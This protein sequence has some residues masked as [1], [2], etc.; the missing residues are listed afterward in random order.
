MGYRYGGTHTQP[1]YE[2]AGGSGL[3]T[4]RVFEVAFGGHPY[5]IDWS[6]EAPLHH[7]TVPMTREQADV[8][9]SPGEQ[10]INREA[11]WR[12]F[13][14]SWHHG[15]GQRFFDRPESLPHHFRESKG[16]D[17]WTRF[18][19][20]L[21]NDTELVES[22]SAT[23][24]FAVTAGNFLYFVDGTDLKVWEDDLSGSPAT[25]T[26]LPATAPTAMASDG[27][28][29]WTAH[30]DD[31]IYRT[32]RGGAAAVERLEGPVT[33]V[34]FVAG[35][36]VAAHEGSFWDVTAEGMD[37]GAAEPLP[38]ATHVHPNPDWTWVDFAESSTHIY[39]A[40]FSGDKSH[41]YSTTLQD[42]A[43]A[44]DAPT[45]VASLPHGE[46]VT[47]LTGYLGQFLLVGTNQGWRFAATNENGTLSLG[48]LVETSE[49]VLAGFGRGPFMW[50]GLTNYDEESTGL[51][52]LS[53][54]IFGDPELFVPSHGSDLMIDGS[55]NV[56]SIVSFGGQ[57][58][59]TVDGMGLIGESSDLV[60]DGHLDTGL[61]SWGMTEQKL[62]L[63]MA[64]DHDGDNQGAV[65]IL[66]RTSHTAF[67]PIGTHVGSHSH[68]HPP[69]ALGELSATNFEFR[70]RLIRDPVELDQGQRFLS[71]LFRSQV[72]ARASSLIL[73]TILI[74]PETDTLT[75]AGA[76]MVTHRE[77]AHIHQIWES[78]QL[79]TWQEGDRAWSVFLEDYDAKVHRL[80][81]GQGGHFGT[82]TSVFL[83]MKKV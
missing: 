26:D 70:I 57:I 15:S 50:F 35:R 34:R 9:D 31:G 63:W 21:L 13:S 20:T 11:L 30:G 79:T 5:Q 71:W 52:R 55:G 33:L 66:A 23:N 58:L 61:I 16:I 44:L 36:L 12:R 53:T 69:F 24:L 83:K 43:T 67:S 19:L 42:D 17:F 78:Q 4:A 80:L 54:S 73:A 82:N 2:G 48:A 22:S 51:G 68:Q 27:F 3:A 28:H 41:I 60:P 32:D 77:R 46:V 45:V 38:T 62:G 40:G 74:A 7:T 72:R 1:L 47:S 39:A 29:V 37:S 14:E 49:P 81:T 65:Q 25:I 6:A 64:I 59:Y 18:E 75:D 56:T 76:S 10:S 8:S